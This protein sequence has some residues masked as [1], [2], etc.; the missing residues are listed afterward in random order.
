MRSIVAALVLA[1][2]PCACA[3]Q[4]KE[5]PP[6]PFVGTR[7][8]V[9]L[10]LPIQG[11]Q[12]YFRFGD[13]R[14]EGFAGCS[15]VRAEYL[16]DSVGTRTIA[17][18]RIEVDRRVCDASV[19]AVE[20]RILGVMQSVSSYSVEGDVMRMSGS[21]GSLTLLA[22]P[23]DAA[24]VAAAPGAPVAIQPIGSLAATRWIGVVDPGT[25]EGNV[26]RLELVAEG[27]LAGYTGCNLMNGSWSVREGE[28]RIG[29][30][31]T[32][33]RACAGPESEVEKRLVAAFAEGRLVRE[34]NKLVAIGKGG[35]RFE[36]IPARN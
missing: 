26:P 18:R 9:V 15:M 12:P 10:E 21:G 16:S 23:H 25:P 32:T 13:G 29:P 11:Q 24:L 7:W 27:R 8:Q 5:L 6:K 35:E 30:L 28:G 17:L 36:F 3:L 33:K 2:L 22:T 19:K 1:V 14:M 31:V 34:G 20:N 4:Q